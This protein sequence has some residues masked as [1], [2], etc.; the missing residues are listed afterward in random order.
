MSW[1]AR[2][3][4]LLLFLLAGVTV[5]SALAGPQ[6]VPNERDVARA[7]RPL[8]AGEDYER[9]PALEGHWIAGN[10]VVEPRERETRVAGAVP[11]RL[12]KLLVREGEKVQAGQILAVLENSIES[13]TLAGA[14]A[15]VRAAAAELAKVAHG[16]RAEDVAA[17]VAD[18]ESLE[19]KA[20]LSR[21]ALRRAR[22]LGAHGAATEEELERAEQ[23]A[24]ADD[25]ALESARAKLK[26]AKSGSRREEIALA[27]A[28]LDSAEARMRQADAQ[29]EQRRILA[30]I[31]GE[32]LQLKLRPGEYYLPGSAEPL[33]VLGDT[34]HLRARVDVDEREVA[35]VARGARAF[36]TSSAFGDR[37][38]P[39]RVIE[40]ARRMGRKNVRS[41]DPTE[42]LDTKI[43]ETVLELEDAAGLF[44]GMRVV[45]YIE[46]TGE[47]LANAGKRP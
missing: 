25:K 23:Q 2:A 33:A 40:L 28:K 45:G 21:R 39:A 17:V 44:P 8:A 47:P 9:A 35:L 34:E 3:G 10:G 12:E 5:R 37:K 18:T 22:R 27:R 16:M 29:L 41:D 38:F 14:Q 43:L 15:D 13:A 26:A 20:S 4:W 42:R 36:V 30:P 1:S 7:S 32:V 11:G 6:N 19:A 46:R 31:A 24:A